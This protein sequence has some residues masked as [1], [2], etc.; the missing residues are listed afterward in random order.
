MGLFSKKGTSGKGDQKQT[1]VPEE[2]R[3]SFKRGVGKT[4]TYLKTRK[5]SDFNPAKSVGLRLFLV[6]FIAIVVFVVSLGILSYQTARSTIQENAKNANLQTVTQTT[7]KLDI[8]FNRFGDELHQV[9]FD[10]DLQSNLTGLTDKGVSNYDQFMYTKNISQKISSFTFTQNGIRGVY[11]ISTDNQFNPITAGTT[12]PDFLNNYS[13]ESWYNDLKTQGGKAW[14]PVDNGSSFR[15]AESL[16]GLSG[17]SRY[18]IAIDLDLNLINNQLVN[19]SLGKGSKIQMVTDTGKII[20]SSVN[21]ENGT[22]SS[23][24]DIAKATN[25]TSSLNTKDGGGDSMLAVYDTMESSGWKLVGIV[26]VDNLVSDAKQILTTTLIAAIIVALIAVAIGLWMVRMIAHPLTLMNRLMQEGA[27]GNLNVRMKHTGKDEIGQLSGSFNKMMEQIT[28]L[29]THANNSASEVLGTASELAEASRKTAL[30]AKEIAIATEEIA[31]GAGSL[32]NEA[33]RGSELTEN[34]GSQVSA[35]IASNQEMQASARE[36]EQSSEMGTHFLQGLTDKTNFTGQMTR[37]L[38]ERVNSLQASSAS[39]MK[40]LDV[41][42][43]IAQQTN[44]LSLNATIE[45]A[46][47]GAAGRGFMVVADEIRQLAEQSKQSIAMVG[48][49]TDQIQQEMN[50]TIKALEEVN[51]LFEQQIQSV[52]ETS[53][54]FVSVQG[55]MNQFVTKLDAVS[56]SITGLSEAQSTLSE[57]MTNVSAVAEESSATSEEVASLSNE[58]QTVGDQLVQLSGKLEKVSD[59]LKESLSKFKI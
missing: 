23:F 33:E 30:S 16:K 10:Q 34:I 22:Q 31:N 28:E 1:S 58:Q 24:M 26:P 14:L 6:F 42:Q 49:I 32:A 53:E 41:M 51:P 54:I 13:K 20:V 57:A 8:I 45:A 2:Q 27:G 17:S 39:V 12:D 7:E 29:V 40:V 4:F 3:H 35:V 47:A 52:N 44:I 25:K 46:R 18:L 43:N 48:Q 37:A 38:A 11:L 15:Y 9:F 50:E 56:A 5:I 36:V 55:Q 21:T 59:Q 19:V